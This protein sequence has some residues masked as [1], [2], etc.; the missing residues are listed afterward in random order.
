MSD[1]ALSQALREFSKGEGHDWFGDRVGG[2]G[3]GVAGLD[4]AFTKLDQ[5]IR[6]CEGA[7]T[8]AVKKQDTPAENVKPKPAPASAQSQQPTMQRTQSQQRPAAQPRQHSR[9]SVKQEVI[10]LD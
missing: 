7:A 1:D 5:A 3:A 10:E 2:F 9:N 4:E 8:V 6:K